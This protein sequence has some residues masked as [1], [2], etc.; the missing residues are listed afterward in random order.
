VPITNE[1]QVSEHVYAG[2][3]PS[4]SKQIAH[5]QLEKL[6]EQ[7][8]ERSLDCGNCMD[9]DALVER[10]QPTTCCIFGGKLVLHRLQNRAICRDVAPLNE[11]P[12]Q[13]EDAPNLLSAGHFAHPNI[14]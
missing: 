7:I 12:G 10:L 3:L 1:E 13:F 9:G 4:V 6:P 2:T 11:R 8:K 14:A 5:R